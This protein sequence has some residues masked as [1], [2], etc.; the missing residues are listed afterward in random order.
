M[1]LRY[2]AMVLRYRNRNSLTWWYRWG[3]CWNTD[4]EIWVP[5]AVF[6][7]IVARRSIISLQIQNHSRFQDNRSTHIQLPWT[8]LYPKRI[9]KLCDFR[10]AL[11]VQVHLNSSTKYC[12][13][14]LISTI[15]STYSCLKNAHTSINGFKRKST[16]Q[17]QGVSNEGKRR[18]TRRMTCKSTQRKQLLTFSIQ[19]QPKTW[20]RS[21]QILRYQS[22][23]RR[24]YMFSFASLKSQMR[25]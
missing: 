18:I 8:K 1:E 7:G 14:V 6:T 15:Y 21:R 5:F 3:L 10:T 24:L 23:D 22:K 25:F 13:E 16:S 11:N 9:Q 17:S 2:F 20:K 12:Q 19:L 4:T